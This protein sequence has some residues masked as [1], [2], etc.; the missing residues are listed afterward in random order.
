MEIVSVINNS[1]SLRMFVNFK[2]DFVASIIVFLVAVP[3][4]IS[5]SS[6]C[7]LSPFV[8][9]ISGIIGGIVVG[10]FSGCPL[11]VSGPAAGLITIIWDTIQKYGIEHFGVIVLFSGIIQ[12]I[13]GLCHLAPWFRA[14]SPAIV[15]GMLSGIGLTII[16]S[17]SHVLLDHIPT[18]NVITNFLTIPEAFVK[19]IVN[20]TTTTHHLAALI[21][22]LTLSILFL[23]NVIPQKYKFLPPTLVAIIVSIIV[24]NILNMPIKYVEISGNIL[25][26]INFINISS[27]A[28]LAKSDAI[29]AAISIAF[30]ASAETLLSAT[31]VDNLKTKGPKTDYNKEIFAQGL[32]NS[33][34]GLI[35]ALPITGVIVRSAANINAGG[36]SRASTIIH[37]FWILIF[38]SIFPFLLGYIPSASLAAI[39]VYTGVKLVNVKFIRD[40]FKIS[41]GEFIIYISTVIA[42]L[43]T[44]LL[45]GII[46]GVVL[47]IIKIIYKTARFD[48][49]VSN[50]N[51]TDDIVI[52]ISG[53]P[54]FLRL[55]QIASVIEE[56]SPNKKIN[57]VFDRMT[58]IDHA[59]VDLLI[60]W[61]NRYDKTGK[62]IKIDWEYLKRIVPDFG[63]DL[64]DEQHSNIQTNSIPYKIRDCAKCKYHFNSENDLTDEETD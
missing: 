62:N 41:R 4:C 9:L 40:I 28:H 34:A 38:V 20:Y 23:W 63:W 53:N 50:I 46:I 14:V 24:S 18:N 1:T 56:I 22:F 43:L 42:I 57:I 13:I 55:P 61:S 59:I 17:Q 6:A 36:V 27:F 15:Q 64:L 60:G 54:T 33:I 32:G 58:L 12:I 45:E 3:L 39:L 37:G 30:I 5:I 52:K 25:D 16:G 8:G 47:S 11:Q 49:I 7:G 21:G 19:G 48:I 26:S 2:K 51:D 10:S 44:N 31:A 29:I 35:G